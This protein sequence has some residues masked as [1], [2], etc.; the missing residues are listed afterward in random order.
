MTQLPD[1]VLEFAFE[2]RV[3]VDPPLRVGGTS[4]RE[5]LHVVPITGGTVDG[6]RLR[7]EVLPGGEDWYVDRDGV[8]TLDA[9]YVLKADD[10]ALIAI[11]NRGFWRASPEVTARLDAG[12]P[13]S[14]TE[15]YYRTSP[16]FTTE[17]PAHRW[18][19]ETVLV[20]LARE[21]RGDVCIRFFALT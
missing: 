2:V 3:H 9:R 6:P 8:I 18:L 10:G 13:V 15:Y 20:G 4:P 5:A 11:T 1:P 17:A 21:D 14:E 19:T 12:E 16:V 7:G